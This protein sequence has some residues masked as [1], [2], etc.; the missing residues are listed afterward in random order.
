MMV[1]R[2]Y[3]LG[4]LMGLMDL[5]LPPVVNQLQMAQ[6]V[7]YIIDLIKHS[8]DPDSWADNGRDGP[9]T[10]AFE[11]LTMSLVVRQSAEVHFMLGGSLR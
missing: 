5:R 11:P 6:N 7:A 9:G 4:D 3:Y 8:V 1:V 2:T 10:I